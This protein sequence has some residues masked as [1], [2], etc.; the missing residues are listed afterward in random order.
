MALRKQAEID[1][2][3]ATL[4]TVPGTVPGVI[5]TVFPAGSP[6][7]ISSPTS[8]SKAGGAAAVTVSLN[9]KGTSGP[10]RKVT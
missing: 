9:L 3:R 4:G 8:C 1:A 5:Q 6:A 10:V 7:A 2:P